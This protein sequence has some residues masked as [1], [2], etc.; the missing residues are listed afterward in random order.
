MKKV[1]GYLLIVALV[2]GLS[3]GCS[4]STTPETPPET[5]AG[6]GERQIAKQIVIGRIQDSDDLDPVTQ[7]GNVNIGCLILCLKDY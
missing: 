7:D 4:P 3:V 1:L 6:S 2:V 5:D